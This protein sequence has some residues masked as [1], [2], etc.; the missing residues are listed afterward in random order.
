MILWT[1]GDL[2]II[3]VTLYGAGLFLEFISLI[4]FRIKLP[5]ESRPFKI[6]LNVVGLCLLILLPVG[7]YSI[8]LSSAFL[9]SEKM[10]PPAL[11]ALGALISAELIWRIIVWRKPFLKNKR[12]NRP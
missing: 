2:L 10:L 1:F 9:S 4:I 6:P 7:V 3:D 12:G 5:N 11:F 8:A